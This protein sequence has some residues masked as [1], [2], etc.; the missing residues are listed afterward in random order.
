MKPTFLAVSMF[1]AALVMS[2][3]VRADEFNPI[4]SAS[5]PD[6]E[7]A[8]TYTFTL[9]PGSTSGWHYHQ[10]LIWVEVI[11]GSLTEDR[12]CGLPLVEH[13]AGTAFAEVPGVVHTV[14][15]TGNVTAVP[16]LEGVGPSCTADY[17]DL[18]PVSGPSCNKAGNK[19]KRIEGPYCPN[20]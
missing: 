5:L 20:Q 3:L 19:P 1:I 7:I 12:G 9:D 2:P 15:N 13:Q 11:S 10:G 4:A 6:G 8:E 18:V 17:N 16:A 14:T